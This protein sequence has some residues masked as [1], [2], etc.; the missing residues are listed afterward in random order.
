MWREFIFILPANK[1]S[2]P[3]TGAMFAVYQKA[4]LMASLALPGSSV[5][6]IADSVYCLVC[7]LLTWRI[8]SI[9]RAFIA[10]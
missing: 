4:L 2:N 9:K 7:D 8:D 6:K 5:L 3:L 10:C 1:A